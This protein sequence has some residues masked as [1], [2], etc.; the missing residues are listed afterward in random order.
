M[1]VERP[2]RQPG[3]RSRRN[4]H[5]LGCKLGKVATPADLGVDGWRPLQPWKG[6]APMGGWFVID[7]AEEAN[8]SRIAEAALTRVRE[9]QADA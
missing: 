5:G 4:G 7:V 8:W 2:A 6:K 1:R 9:E 3:A